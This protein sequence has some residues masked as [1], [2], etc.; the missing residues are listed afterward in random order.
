VYVRDFMALDALSPQALAAAATLLHTCYRS[1]DLVHR[2]LEALDQKTQG[3]YAPRYMN[4][5]R[6]LLA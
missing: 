3:F 1:Y 6:V 5:L 4:R 2:I